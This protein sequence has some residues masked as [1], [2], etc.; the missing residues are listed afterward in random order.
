MG[1]DKGSG[2]GKI[3][4][5]GQ[6]REGDRGRREGTGGGGTGG[7]ERQERG[8]REGEG[9]NLFP[10]VAMPIGYGLSYCTSI[11]VNTGDVCDGSELE[12]NKLRRLEGL[13]FQ[14]LESLLSL[15]LKRNTISELMDG[16]F[17]GLGK[18]LSL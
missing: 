1:R 12:R 15:K 17:W 9:R 10:T 11:I 7:E 8:R 14:G 13:V 5:D 6:L 3:G 18:I 4:G 16:T 2:R